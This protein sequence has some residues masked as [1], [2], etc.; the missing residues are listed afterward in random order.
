MTTYDGTP[1]GF[2][3]TGRAMAS[4]ANGDYGHC[5][6]QMCT[7]ADEP[8]LHSEDGDSE[9]AARRLRSPATVEQV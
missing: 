4:G 9:P 8:L 2:R 1:H 6:G 5:D 7:H 3:A